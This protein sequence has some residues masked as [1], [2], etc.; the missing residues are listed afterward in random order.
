MMIW[1]TEQYQE[2]IK[3]LGRPKAFQALRE[4]EWFENALALARR[5]NIR[6]F[7]YELEFSEV[8]FSDTGR[9]SDA[10]FDAVIGNPPYDVLSE[11][12]TRHDLRAL[13]AVIDH[14]KF[15]APSKVGKNNLYKLFVCRSVE[16]LADGWK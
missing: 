1:C 7:H 13:R 16:L 15:F 6:A 3:N 5:D 10:G 12:E 9:R 8:Y 14:E 2:A 4:A 11:L